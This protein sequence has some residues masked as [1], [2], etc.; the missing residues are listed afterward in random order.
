M[1]SSKGNVATAWIFG[2]F[3]PA[4]LLSRQ[5][6]TITGVNGLKGFWL[7]IGLIDSANVP[8]PLLSVITWL[9]ATVV[10]KC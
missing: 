10:Q 8:I 1:E 5:I 6:W 4:S 2:S 3:L 7:P 9:K